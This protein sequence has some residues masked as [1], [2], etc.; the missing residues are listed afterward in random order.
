MALHS[1]RMLLITAFIAGAAYSRGLHAD[2]PAPATKRNPAGQTLEQAV[3]REITAILDAIQENGKFD[4]ARDRLSGLFD[5]VALLGAEKN[6]DAF[7]DVDFALRLV[8]QIA[9]VPEPDRL[10]LLRYLRA[11]DTLARTL[12]FLIDDDKQ[13]KGAYAVLNRLR[14]SARRATQ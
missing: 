3:H 11:N 5:S 8:R 9:E 7:R 14:K 6:L 4:A 2:T 13:A 1:S 12:A 10:D